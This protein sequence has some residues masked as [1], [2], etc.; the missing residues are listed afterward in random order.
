[1]LSLITY[2]KHTRFERAAGNKLCSQVSDVLI[3]EYEVDLLLC[4][5]VEK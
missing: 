4:N 5:V 3:K 1:M 2:L